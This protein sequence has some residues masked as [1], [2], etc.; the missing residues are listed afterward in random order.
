MPNFKLSDKADNDLY[1]IGV[2]TEDTHGLE[3]RNKYLNEISQRFHLLAENPDYP[4]SKDI[5][6]IKNGCFSLSINEHFIIYRKYSYGVRIV[7]ILG[8]VMD[9]ERHL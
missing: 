9:L 6:H 2:Y 8:Q 4:T 3:Q 5:S 1:G 7:R